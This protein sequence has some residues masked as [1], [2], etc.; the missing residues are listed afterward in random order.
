LVCPKKPRNKKTVK[1]KNRQKR[2]QERRIKRGGRDQ[3]EPRKGWKKSDA[4]KE[5]GVKKKNL[6]GGV[7]MK[8][9]RS[10]SNT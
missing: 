2:D 8:S 10:D 6:K 3:L 7:N 9:K 5:N 1:K 4:L